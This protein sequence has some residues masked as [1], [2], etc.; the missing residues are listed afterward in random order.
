MTEVLHRAF[1]HQANGIIHISDGINEVIYETVADFLIDEAAYFLPSNSI[2][3]SY[4][5]PGA[6]SF[7]HVLVD[8]GSVSNGSFPD[9]TLEGYI[10]NIGLYLAAKANR[11][12]EL[13]QW[14]VLA[15]AKAEAIWHV[16]EQA[17]MKIGPTDWWITRNV[18]SAEAIPAAVVT[19]RAAVKVESAAREAAVTSAPNMNAVWALFDAIPDSNWPTI[20]IYYLRGTSSLQST[21]PAP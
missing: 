8:D 15:D 17:W 9:A 11:E 2:G 7:H 21:P 6:V 3:R 20:D 1:C 14:P 5:N 4:E 18:E 19:F 12:H 16:K 10:N 13:Y